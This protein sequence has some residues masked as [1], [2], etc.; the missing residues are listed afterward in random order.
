MYKREKKV[1]THI[2]TL[3][4]KHL[5]FIGILDLLAV[6][7]SFVRFFFNQDA[8]FFL[9]IRTI[10]II[11]VFHMLHMEKFEYAGEAMFKQIAATKYRY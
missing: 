11:K 2:I 5:K 10:R 1:K 8:G 7:P 3:N 4:T 9:T 6:I